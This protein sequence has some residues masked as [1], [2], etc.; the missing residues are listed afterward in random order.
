[1]V[2]S[3][4]TGAVS[5]HVHRLW[6]LSS[7]WVHCSRPPVFTGRG[8]MERWLL[9]QETWLDSLLRK[10]S[11]LTKRWAVIIRLIAIEIQVILRLLFCTCALHYKSTVSGQA[12]ENLRT[13]IMLVQ[14]AYPWPSVSSA[15][16]RIHNNLG[17]VW[18]NH[19]GGSGYF[20]A[21]VGWGPDRCSSARILSWGGI[22]VTKPQSVSHAACTSEQNWITVL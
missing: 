11:R 5:S 21:K 19:T 12:I 4:S 18:W 8:P 22:L 1:M 7:E 15:E 6:A 16:F 17:E 3:L 20:L 2:G 10:N 13:M 9:L 14:R